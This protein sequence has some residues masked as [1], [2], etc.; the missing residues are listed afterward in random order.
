MSRLEGEVRPDPENGNIRIAR[1]ADLMRDNPAALIVNKES[2]ERMAG[3]FTYGPEGQ[4]E[5]PHVVKV[6]TFSSEHGGVIRDFVLDGM[7]RTK[8]VYDNENNPAVI[9]S[10][11]QFTVKD[12]TQAV[13]QNPAIIPVEERTEGQEALTMLQYLRAIIPP[14]VEHS[15]IAPDRMAAHLINGWENMVG[16]DLAK[17]YS[18]LAA[19][20]F[21]SNQDVLNIATDEALKKDLDKQPQIMAGE[22]LDERVLLQQKLTEMAAVIRQTRP[23]TRHEIAKAAFMLVSASSPVIGGD[24]R[25]R[26]QIYGLLSSPEVGRKLEE[27]FPDSSIRAQMKDQLDKFISDAFKRF[28]KHPHKG[29]ILDVL[30]RALKHSQLTYNHIVDVYSSQNP[31]KRYD[32]VR[33]DIN[34]NRLTR[35]YKASFRGQELTEAESRLINALGRKTEL[36]DA[37]ISGLTKLIK[38]ADNMLVKAEE[39]K[40]KLFQ[41]R[42]ELITRGVDSRLLDEANATLQA[43]QEAIATSISAYNVKGSIG[44]LLETINLINNRMD[45]Q[46]AIYQVGETVDQITGEKLKAGYGPQIRKDIVSLVY[47][48]F[49]KINPNN[50]VKVRQRIQQLAL[51]DHE[52]LLRV[53]T[54]DLP[55]TVALQRQRERRA[56]IETRAPVTPTT[57]KPPLP[58]TPPTRPSSLRVDIGTGTKPPS[59]NLP[60]EDEIIKTQDLEKQRKQNSKDRLFRLLNNLTEGLNEVYLNFEDLTDEEKR[61]LYQ[62][63]R[64]LGKLAYNQPDLHRLVT[65]IHP[66]LKE[67]YEKLRSAHVYQAIEDAQKDSRTGR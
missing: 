59:S 27:A 21:L 13:L 34:E 57:E 12:V 6:K 33:E 19:L 67:S 48:E 25:S 18:A 7:T 3:N 61:P 5:S 35:T 53:K 64:R 58:V 15:Q 20:S 43:K 52:F 30:G 9:P 39:L 28:D 17:K 51:L 49:G 47:G 32:E 62:A 66:H 10:D 42:D 1:P 41:E 50:L 63:I 2:Y 23:L 22:T 24:R 45:Y 54:G 26:E 60:K 65:E 44:A 14:T 31:V 4:F 40:T 37:D 38:A 8:F 36:T 46:M 56:S 16:E 29:E 55:L 11:F